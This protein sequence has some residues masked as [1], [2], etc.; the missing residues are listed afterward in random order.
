MQI[1]NTLTR[2]K[3][4]FRPLVENE[5]KIYVCGPTVYNYIHI[6]NARPIVVFD[7]LRR[8]LSYKGMD[9]TYVSNFTDID[10]KIIN[11]AKEENVPYNEITKKYIDAYLEDT[12]GLNILE[13]ATIHPRATDYIEQMVDFIGGLINIDAA[14]NVD[15]NVYFDISKARDYGILSKKNIEDLKAGARVD[16]S[17]EK[18]NPLDFALWKKQKEA[19]EP[20][21]DSPWG[22][23]RPGWHIECSVMARSI[24]GDTIDIHA[25]GE[26]LQFPHHENEIAQSQTLT[27]KTFSNYW[28]HNGMINIDNEKMSKSKGNFFLVR[29]VAESYD[30]EIIRLWLLSAHYRSPINFSQEVMDHTKNAL[31]RLYNAKYKLERLDKSVETGEID[32]DLK[33]KIDRQ[34]QLFDRAMAD[35]LNTADAISH[36]FDLVSLINT[37]INEGTSQETVAYAY[38]TYMDLVGVLGLLFR[39]LEEVDKWIEDMINQRQ[40]ARSAKDFVLADQIRDRLLEE[41]IE[42]EDTR[43]GVVWKRRS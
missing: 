28:M 29:E 13:E 41:G 18:R 43:S 35:D 4:D 10:D 22:P 7:T 36:V 26:D 24:L 25:G 37:D 6:G 2:K 31:D 30:R 8:Y 34:V 14:Y 17:D 19:W 23:G 21:W 38:R 5:A 32:Q 3:E 15:G 27:G 11:K 20:A 9:V 16:A 39:D 33:D 42:L 40:E 12:K 1:Y